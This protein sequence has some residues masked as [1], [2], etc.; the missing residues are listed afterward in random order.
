M[1]QKEKK[2]LIGLKIKNY[3]CAKN[4]TQEDLAGE[5]N[6]DASTLSRIEIGRTF[7]SFDTAEKILRVLEINPYEFFELD[8]NS[9]PDLS[10]TDKII[11]EIVKSLT[12][13]EKQKV[14]Q[15]LETFILN[16]D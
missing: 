14:L 6:I 13:R 2:R 12:P 4:Y 10:E 7:P 5:I 11:I 15:F 16:I 1:G 3:R 9:T 8:K